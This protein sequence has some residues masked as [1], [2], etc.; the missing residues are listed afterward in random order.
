MISWRDRDVG[1]CPRRVCACG[2]PGLSSANQRARA[3]RGPN[4]GPN[5]GH[6]EGTNEGHNQH[7]R[8]EVLL[9]AV[10]EFSKLPTIQAAHHPS[11]PP[12]KGSQAP[13][14]TDD[15]VAARS[16][17]ILAIHTDLQPAQRPTWLFTPTCPTWLP[18]APPPPPPVAGG[19]SL[20]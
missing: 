3:P 1:V 20:A 15:I 17:A 10:D 12:S 16:K 2:V 5:E 13:H 8:L 11:C 19:P 18:A 4:E 6:D 9:E 14:H 7:E